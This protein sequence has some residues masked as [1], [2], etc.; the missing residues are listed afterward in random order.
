MCKCE[1]D[2]PHLSISLYYNIIINRNYLLKFQ[3]VNE[4]NRT[5]IWLLYKFK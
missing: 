5:R 4:C 3:G 1:I 2:S